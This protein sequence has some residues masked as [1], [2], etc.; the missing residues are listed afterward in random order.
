MSITA[1]YVLCRWVH[2]AT[3]L[4][5]FGL[6]LFVG[7][8]APPVLRHNLEKQ[9]RALLGT[10]L[11]LCAF[12]SWLMVTLQA[13]QMGDG[14]QDVIS[15]ET[16]LAVM[17]TTFGEAWLLQLI[18]SSLLLIAPLFT[19][20]IRRFLLT[21]FAA[22]LLITLARTGHASAEQGISGIAHRL[23]NGI[24][25]L[26]AG[27]WFGGLLPFWLCVRQLSGAAKA[28]AMQAVIRYSRWGH[29]AVALVI[30]TGIGNVAWILGG[31]P[32]VLDSVYQ[33]GLWLKIL[34][35]A[36]MIGIALYNRYRVVRS[37]GQNRQRALTLLAGNAVVEWLLALLVLLTVSF[38]AT[39]PPI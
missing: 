17:Q 36:V 16:W 13:G 18:F 23:N 33:R 2:F 21:L 19:P 4:Q 6:A 11:V 34:L 25:L 12:S 10:S 27:F 5:I 8:I 37:M 32:R 22:L 38:F 9:T 30:V 3:A 24:H 1:L 35:V 28:F 39:Q 15:P 26:S 20:N 7:W 14:W 29:L 31:W